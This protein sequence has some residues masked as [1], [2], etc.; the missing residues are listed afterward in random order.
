MLF[1]NIVLLKLEHETDVNEH[2]LL[3]KSLHNAKPVSDSL[4]RSIP[5]FEFHGHDNDCV[6][7]SHAAD[8]TCCTT[9]KRKNYF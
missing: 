1:V 5:E 9:L 7:K 6:F 8:L 3:P 4:F 2:P